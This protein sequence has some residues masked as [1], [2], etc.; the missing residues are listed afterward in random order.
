MT[1]WSACEIIFLLSRLLHSLVIYW[2]YIPLHLPSSYNDVVLYSIS[3]LYCCI[4]AADSSPCRPCCLIL[5]FQSEFQQVCASYDKVRAEFRAWS[6]PTF[7]IPEPAL[8]PSAPPT[9]QS[10]K[11]TANDEEESTTSKVCRPLSCFVSWLL[12]FCFSALLVQ[13]DL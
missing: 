7:A 13:L 1:F 2:S 8:P 12:C 10:V 3:K 9:A 11:T 6:R 5:L 4:S